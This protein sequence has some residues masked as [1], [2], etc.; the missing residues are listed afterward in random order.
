M[1][2]EMKVVDIQTVK[3]INRIIFNI[4][5]LI[6]I[7]INQFNY[8]VSKLQIIILYTLKINN[9]II[10]ELLTT[11]NIKLSIFRI[12]LSFLCKLNII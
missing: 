11:L 10:D 5:K 6:I 7:I 8:K 3:V 4:S 9:F 12:L 1:R 2:F